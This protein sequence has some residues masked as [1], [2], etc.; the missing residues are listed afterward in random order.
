VNVHFRWLNPKGNVKLDVTL[1][2][3]NNG[4]WPEVCAG[5]F[6]PLP[7]KIGDRLQATVGS[8]MR[9]LKIPTLRIR[10]DSTTD[11]FFGKAPAKSQLR[12]G[13][14]G[15]TSE[16]LVRVNK[17]GRWNYRDPGF[18]VPAGLHA[19]AR[20]TSAHGDVVTFENVAF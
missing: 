3:N 18:D 7:L 20:W 6:K 15:I 8:T 16:V 1:R 4:Y 17:F 13:W 9:T 5:T 11:R 14:D 12:L 10:I 19:Y 2:T